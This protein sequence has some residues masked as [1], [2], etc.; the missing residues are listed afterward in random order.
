MASTDD[1]PSSAFGPRLCSTVCMLTGAY[2]LSRR[3]VT[4]VLEEIFGI[5]MSLGSVSNIEGR[6]AKALEAAS[7]EAMAHATSAAVKHVD[8]TSWIRDAQRSSAWVFACVAVSVF[9][10]VADGRRGT[11]RKL[12]K[13]RRGVLVSDRASVFLFWSMKPPESNSRRASRSVTKESW[14]WYAGVESPVGMDLVTL[15]SL[16]QHRD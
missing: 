1:I 16:H 9:R 2:H 14:L 3:Q 10:I 4:V 6:M 15:G 7:D 12:L 13:R 8:E 5:H 11:F